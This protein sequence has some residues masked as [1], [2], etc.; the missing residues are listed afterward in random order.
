MRTLWLIPVLAGLVGACGISKEEHDKQVQ[1]ALDEQKS[2]L[3]AEMKKAQAACDDDKKNLT[4]KHQEV[5]ASKDQM[6]LGLE[7]EVKKKGGDLQA[8]RSELGERAAALA[9]A[10]TE[11]A[12]TT[13]EV[14][15][16]RRLRAEAEKEAAQFKALA[17]RLKSMIDSG[18]LQVVMRDGRINLKLPDN[19]L[20]PSGSKDL[21]KDGTAALLEVA[22]VLKDVKDRDFL[23]AGHTDNVALKKGGRFKDNWELSTARAVTVVKLLVANG[24]APENLA[25]AGFGEFDPIASNETPE[26]QAQNRRLEIILLPR[27]EQ[28]NM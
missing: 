14:E 3:D 12:A 10:K 13:A 4:T 22:A 24:V 21:K 15:Q 26:G 9:S 2:R 16:L 1:S 28:V 11:L 25:A 20:F 7:S 6:I 17:E 8:V 5:V 23:I 19:V 27:L 18:R